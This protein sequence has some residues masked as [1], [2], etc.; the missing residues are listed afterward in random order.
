MRV[1]N[2]LAVVVAVVGTVA[3]VGLPAETL[4]ESARLDEM[5]VVAVVGTVAG[6]VAFVALDLVAEAPKCQ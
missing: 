3:V 2:P 4:E 5:A 6:L 1:R